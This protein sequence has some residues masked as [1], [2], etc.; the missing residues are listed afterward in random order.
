MQGPSYLAWL[1][2]ISRDANGSDLAT[3][4]VQAK[5][6][7]QFILANQRGLQGLDVCTFGYPF[8]GLKRIAGEM[9]APNLEIRLFKG[10]IMRTSEFEYPEF[11]PTISYETSFPAPGGLSGAPLI[12][13]LTRRV[14]GVVYGNNDVAKTEHFAAVDSDG[15]KSPEIQRLVSFGLAHHTNT[16]RNLSGTATNQRM[17]AEIIPSG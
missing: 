5:P 1:Y 13:L 12:E 17:L 4:N 3:A 8:S 11:G 7:F 9:A 14:L 6:D 16:L 15:T 10:Y 2:N